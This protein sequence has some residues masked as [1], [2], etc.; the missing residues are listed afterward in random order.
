M[1]FHETKIDDRAYLFLDIGEGP[2]TKIVDFNII[3]QFSRPED[4]YKEKFFELA[5]AKVQSRI[6]IKEDIEIAAKNLLIFLQNDGYVNAKL[7]RVFVS[8]ERENPGNGVL[9]IQLDEGPQ[10]KIADIK[11]NGVSPGNLSGVTAAAGLAKDQS[12]S[13]SQLELS[14]QKIKTYYEGMGYIEYKLLNET[15]DLITY[16]EN[17]SKLE[18]NVHV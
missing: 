14:L 8:T 17:N 12:L 16:S 10:V 18:L 7:T 11:F 9:V 13:L 4:F 2:F 1:P 5:S 6:Y 15:T 3:G